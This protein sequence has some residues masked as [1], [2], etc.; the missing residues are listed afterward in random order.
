MTSVVLAWV[1]V[2]IGYIIVRASVSLK[3]LQNGTIVYGIF[4]LVVEVSPPLSTIPSMLATYQ[5]S[6]TSM[7]IDQ[8]SP[9]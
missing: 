7:L 5:P 9:I 2:T 8:C 1:V 4:V 6:I 3:N